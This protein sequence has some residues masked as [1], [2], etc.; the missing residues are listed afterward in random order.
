MRR[1]T[2]VRGRR[3]TNLGDVNCAAGEGGQNQA[4]YQI[5]MG[6]EPKGGLRGGHFVWLVK[7]LAVNHCRPTVGFEIGKRKIGG[8]KLI[9]ADCLSPGWS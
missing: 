9:R 5:M 4:I 2:R 8:G 6:C 1:K 7:S 3:R